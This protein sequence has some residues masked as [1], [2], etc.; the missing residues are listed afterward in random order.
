MGGRGW[1][2]GCSARRDHQGE[3]KNKTSGYVGIVRQCANMGASISFISHAFIF[4]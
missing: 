2:V 3:T 4:V 1:R